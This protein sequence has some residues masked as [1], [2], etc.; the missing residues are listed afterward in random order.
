MAYHASI[1][2]FERTPLRALKSLSA[3]LG[4]KGFYV[5]DESFRLGLNAF[6]ALGAGYAM[7]RWI[8]DRLGI[9]DEDLTFDR[10]VRDEAKKR[11]GPVTFVCATDGNHGRGVAWMAR[12][13]G[14]DCV[15]YLPKG[16]APQ[17]RERGQAGGAVPLG[18]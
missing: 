17:R 13:L 12:L 3:H 11:L 9:A 8:G 1:P 10:L 18:R 4:I 15:V 16:T 14:Q 6:K 2:G 5:K 7:G